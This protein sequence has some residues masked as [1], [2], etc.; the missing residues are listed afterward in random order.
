MISY[1]YNCT[2]IKYCHKRVN[3]CAMLKELEYANLGFRYPHVPYDAPVQLAAVG[4]E[5]VESAL[6][7]WEGMQR[8][9][10]GHF[11]LQYTLEGEG[12]IRIGNETI[13]LR[14]GQVFLVEIPSD[15]C[16]YLPQI[17]PHWEFIFVVL[18][19]DEARKVWHWLILQEGNVFT[20]EPDS[21]VIKTLEVLFRQAYLNEISDSY[22]AAGLAFQLVMEL[23]RGGQFTGNTD[24]LPKGI[25][26]A[27]TFMKHSFAKIASISEVAEHVELSSYYFIRLFQ[28]HTQLT[29]HQYMTHIRMEKAVQLLRESALPI[30]E[31]A[32][33]IG[34]TSGNYFIKVF[35]K[36]V[37]VSPGQF[38]K[39]KEA[40]AFDRIIFH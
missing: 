35:R 5:R 1:I 7:R 26:Q 3:N 16:Y 23:Y 39:A 13:A 25:R 28:Q 37:G 27:I 14:R 22:Q 36:W 24:D 12:A 4:W 8:G 30:H 19:G 2:R 32:E 6:Y 21:E 20:Y 34:F 33:K 17:S 29:P 38:R 10:S 11:L 18:S 40:P 15:H 31:I 9:E